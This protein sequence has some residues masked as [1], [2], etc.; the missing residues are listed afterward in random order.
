MAQQYRREIK[1]YEALRRRDRFTQLAP[2]PSMTWDGLGNPSYRVLKQLVH[3]LVIFQNTL[4]WP[5][6]AG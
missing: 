6:P 5:P 2:N 1:L 4:L 3:N